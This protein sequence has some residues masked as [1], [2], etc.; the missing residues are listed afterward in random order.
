[1]P[2]DAR[3][4]PPSNAG[5]GY[6][7]PPDGPPDEE[8]WGITRGFRSL[9]K[10]PQSNAAPPLPPLTSS[11]LRGLRESGQDDGGV[12]RPSATQPASTSAN[13]VAQLIEDSRSFGD[14]SGANEDTPLRSGVAAALT[15]PG[16]ARPSGAEATQSPQPEASSQGA[17]VEAGALGSP[18]Q[19]LT[20]PS[21]ASVNNLHEFSRPVRT[22]SLPEGADIDPSDSD[23]GGQPLSEPPVLTGAS[24]QESP[25]QTL[26]GQRTKGAELSVPV[27]HSP[28]G[29][30]TDAPALSV[31]VGR[32]PKVE[33][34]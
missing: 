5:H 4:E 18:Q 25:S 29:Q 26:P 21:A 22:L 7:R 15:R 32:K 28:G 14:G 30:R 13:V 1:M 27:A 23:H 6:G 20:L 33:Y 17:V 16:A 11:G 34:F 24:V 3:R 8:P 31:P 19:S 12:H 9:F 2:A 10:W